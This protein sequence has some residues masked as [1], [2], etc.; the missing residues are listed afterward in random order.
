MNA[1]NHLFYNNLGI[2]PFK[3]LAEVGGFSTYTD[4]ELAY[5]FIKQSKSILEL[6]AG[7]G[8]CVDFLIQKKYKG[9][10]I[11][12]E[13]SPILIDHLKDRFPTIEILQ[14]DIKK[15]QLK[16]KVD[17]ALWMWSG[18]I[19][20]SREEQQKS[21]RLVSSHLSQKG[22]LVIDLPRLGYQTIAQH[23]DSQHLHFESPFGNLECFLP[24]LD[25]IKF[26]ASE[27]QFKTVI[28]KDYLT[29]TEKERTLF[30][31]QK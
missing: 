26:Y 27:A 17:A 31:L 19:D 8:R 28:P 10:V 20:F 21:I 22:V 12:V 5:P 16:Q 2:D 3:L 9:R 24:T 25:D 15:L 4:L 23:T 7:Y 6:G 13:Q 14:E 11:A 29:A 18:F 30:I 1:G